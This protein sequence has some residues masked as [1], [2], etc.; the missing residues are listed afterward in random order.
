MISFFIKS[1]C[2][3]SEVSPLNH[4][5]SGIPLSRLCGPKNRRAGNYPKDALTNFPKGTFF[6][7]NDDTNCKHLL[8]E[9]NTDQ[10]L[11]GESDRDG[12]TLGW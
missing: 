9:M 8:I 12:F 7:Q 2:R 5:N 4:E 6:K 10:D 1:F 3:S 11:Q